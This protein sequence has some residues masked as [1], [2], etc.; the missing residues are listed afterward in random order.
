MECVFAGNLGRD[1]EVKEIGNGVTVFNFSV[2]ESKYDRRKKERVTI[3]RRCAVFAKTEAAI[4]YHTGNLVRGA[5]IAILNSEEEQATGKEDKVFTSYSVSKYFVAG[6][7]ESTTTNT[8]TNTNSSSQ[9]TGGND[10]DG[11]N[12]DLPF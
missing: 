5:K 4:K 1:A 3:W 11:G 6:K 7:S 2:A 8:N 10:N 12:D 9:N